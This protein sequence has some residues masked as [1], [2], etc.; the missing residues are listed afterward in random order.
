MSQ[1]VSHSHFYLLSVAACGPTFSQGPSRSVWTVE[2]LW[3][4]Y[5]GTSMGSYE[6]EL[7]AKLFAK[8]ENI[9]LE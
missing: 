1:I 9:V 8:N 7:E 6:A 2:V 3:G 5:E 4:E